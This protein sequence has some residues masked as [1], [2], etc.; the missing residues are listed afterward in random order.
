MRRFVLWAGI[1]S[2]ATVSNPAH[3]PPVSEY[4]DDP[5]LA[6]HV[7]LHA[8]HADLLRRTGDGPAA[9]AAYDRAIAASGNAVEREELERR[10]AGL[11]TST[12]GA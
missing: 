11:A 7:P 10:R 9:L 2:A 4:R 3:E 8:A 6:R 12:S 5:R 1:L